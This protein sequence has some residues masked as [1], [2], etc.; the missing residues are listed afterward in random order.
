MFKNDGGGISTQLATKRI[1]LND[2]EAELTK[3][4]KQELID[5]IEDQK[6]F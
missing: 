4:E 5:Y 3:E 2:P 6:D 1:M